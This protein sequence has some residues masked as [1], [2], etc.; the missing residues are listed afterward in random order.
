[1][2]PFPDSGPQTAVEAKPTQSDLIEA[3]NPPQ[4]P[5]LS[6]MAMMTFRGAAVHP[7]LGPKHP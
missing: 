1:M 4:V 7:S 2:T 5:F 6:M 3:L